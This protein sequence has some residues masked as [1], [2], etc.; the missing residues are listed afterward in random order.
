MKNC[1]QKSLFLIL[2]VHK[3]TEETIKHLEKLFEFSGFLRIDRFLFF[4]FLFSFF[5][6][7]SSRPHNP[8]LKKKLNELYISSGRV[9]ACARST[10]TLSYSAPHA[11]K[12]KKKNERKEKKPIPTRI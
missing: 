10:D 4:L 12:R 2:I 5:L 11:K 6:F 7:I 1:V 8:S 3:T 9:C